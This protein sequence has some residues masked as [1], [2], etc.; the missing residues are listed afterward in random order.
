MSLNPLDAKTRQLE[1]LHAQQASA[2]LETLRRPNSGDE[3]RFVSWL[4]ESPRNVRDFLIMLSLDDA[5]GDIDANRSIKIEALLAQ[6]DAGVASGAF[7]AGRQQ[8]PSPTAR[9]AL[10]GSRRR[11]Q[12]ATLAA[13]VLLAAGGGWAWFA[14]SRAAWTQFETSTGEQRAFELP[15][16][17]VV[18]LN[19]HSHV[20]IRFAAHTRDVRLVR[21]E[22]FFQVHH[23]TS[24]PF[25]VYT[26][27]AMVQA[28]GTEFD[29][30]RRED[31]TVVAVIEGRVNV[32]PASRPAAL[33][34][35]SGNA[36]QGSGPSLPAKTPSRTL[37]ASQEARVSHLGSVSIREVNNV[38]D[39]VAWR[40]RRLIFTDQPLGQ[41]VDEFNR[42][43]ANPIR[44][45]GPGVS[46]RTYTGVFNADDTDS[47][48]EVLA[49]DPALAVD[50][51]PDGIVVRLKQP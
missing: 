6:A 42:Y 12:F 21:G 2:W 29:V 24:R 18:Y 23:D 9:E 34:R 19:T 22:A 40:E 11:R 30:Y 36:F 39:T 51:S 31:G 15:D 47:L 43:R 35:K 10:V 26:D 44:L 17:S 28:V 38:T 37:G 3:G 16:G 25:R 45:E 33:E 8:P 13:S 48:V 49:R 14:H 4:K 50:Q 5:L 32:T 41:I 27:D 1:S 46:T 7:S 20:A